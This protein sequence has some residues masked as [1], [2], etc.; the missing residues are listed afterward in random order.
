MDSIECAARTVLYEQCSESTL[1]RYRT[2]SLGQ[3]TAGERSALKRLTASDNRF[4]RPGWRNGRPTSEAVSTAE[5]GL[6]SS[7][8]GEVSEMRCYSF[9]KAAT[10][11]TWYETGMHQE[12]A[13][14]AE[15]RA[16]L[17]V[18]QELQDAAGHANRTEK[19]K[20]SGQ[21]PD[22]QVDVAACSQKM[23]V[24]IKLGSAALLQAPGQGAKCG[25]R[26][27]RT[28]ARAQESGFGA[29]FETPVQ[30]CISSECSAR[31]HARRGTPS[32]A[33]FERMNRWP[34]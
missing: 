31:G 14:R 13:T 20:R 25:R 5:V 29:D 32:C 16:G 10:G 11:Q 24:S 30:A 23:C 27:R 17:E 7:L 15:P 3:Q 19:I 18:K 28:C 33:R 22:T 9:R 4:Q 21:S 8:Q 1:V 6:A 34:L 2:V 26:D 12:G